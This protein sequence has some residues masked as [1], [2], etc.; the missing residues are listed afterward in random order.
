M[1]LRILGDSICG[2]HVQR[3]PIAPD[4]PWFARH[5]LTGTRAIQPLRGD[6]KQSIYRFRRADARQYRRI[7]TDL[8]ASGIEPRYLQEGRRSTDALHEFVN[9][10]FADMPDALP[11][12]GGASAPATQPAVVALPMPYLHGPKNKSPRVAA[13]RAPETTA[14]FVEWLLRS[15]NWTVRD[16]PDN[17]RRPIRV[18]DICILFRKTVRYAEDLTQRYVRALEARNIEHVLVGSKSFHR[19]E[20]IGTVRAA[21]RSI[22]WPHDELSVYSVLRGALFFISDADLFTFRQRHGRRVP[23]SA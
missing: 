11:L 17:T 14:A 6:P 1:R 20:E 12:T 22:E 5:Q 18:D 23:I 16:E 15:S 7:R 2:G 9:A 13:Q 19:R 21:L 10:A 8:L 4:V 3:I